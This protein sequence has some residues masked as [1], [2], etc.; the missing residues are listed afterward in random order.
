[1]SVI[2][3]NPESVRSFST[4]AS[5]QFAAIRQHLESVT[6]EVVEVRYHGPNATQFKQRCGEI[7]VDLSNALLR[8]LN[9]ISEAVRDA[10]SAIS[11]ALGGERVAIQFDGSPISAPAVP[12][13]S[14]VVDIDTSALEALKP[15]IGR[16]FDSVA[17]T[18]DR[19]LSDLQGTDWLGTAK[20]SAV[21]LV[22]QFSSSARQKVTEL[23]TNLNATIDQQ[24][25]AVRSA[26]R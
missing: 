8:D 22:S 1:M 25:E 16:Q 7:A 20:E 2:R 15:S 10:T 14:D 13:A 23:A 6:R 4:K 3:V 26:D 19:N 18:L 21:D 24:I 5:E 9:N 17:E 11:S 12:P